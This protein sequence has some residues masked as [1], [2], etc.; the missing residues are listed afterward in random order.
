MHTLLGVSSMLLAVLG[1]CVALR[2]S[3]RCAGW[4]ARRDLQLL[5]LAA[6]MV[7]LGL[8][9]LGLHHFVAQVCYLDAPPW[10]ALLGLTL[11][12]AMGAVAL[13]AAA[14]GVARLVLMG[15]LVGRR[16]ALASPQLQAVA[17]RLA[18]QA[19]TTP[20]QVRL[21]AYDRPLALVCGVWRPTLLVSTWMLEHLDPRELEAV[22]AHEVGHLLRR[23][24]LLTWLATVLRDAFCYL[25]TSWIAFRHFQRE[26]ELACDDLAV[27]LT[28][29]P[30][31]LAGALAKVWQR[32]LIEPAWQ[33]AQPLLNRAEPIEDRIARLLA[34]HHAVAPQADSRLVSLAGI[35]L[36]VVTLLV[37]EGANLVVLLAPMGCGPMALL[38]QP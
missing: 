10:D 16:G 9:I 5:V 12:L 4:S 11:P 20:P 30:L 22:L 38:A 15:Q 37:I 36:G 35:A 24:Y 21:C 6:P 3:R 17:D 34:P 26:K 31:A 27:A 2:L 14:F 18:E 1:G 8:A 7:G 25:P 33:G 29:R 32:A 13:G 28:N 23:D 19:R